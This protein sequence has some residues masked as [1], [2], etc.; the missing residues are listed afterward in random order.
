VSGPATGVPQQQSQ[1]DEAQA[2]A[3]S[4]L[5]P[6]PTPASGAAAASVPGPGSAAPDFT[7]TDHHGASRTLS[8]ELALSPAL[9]VFYPF[10]FSGICGGELNELQR[11]LAGFE[12]R[13][14][15]VF[16]V[17]CDPMYSLR[18]Y[19]DREGFGFTLLADFWPHGAVAREYGVFDDQ[20]GCAR[21]GSF[22]VARDG[23][24]SWSVVNPISE[25]RPL[26][27]YLE[28]VDQLTR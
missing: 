10:A 28:A 5:T 9:L 11:N 4:V 1:H 14:V 24:V 12:E 26:D 17:S 20:R 7:L 21:R 19:A 25:A 13:G 16:A 23:T 8:A 2:Q 15:A 6:A 18:T 27:A 3:G 22:L